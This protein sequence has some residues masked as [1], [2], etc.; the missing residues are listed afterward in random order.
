MLAEDLA[1][2]RRTDDE[3]GRSRGLRPRL[4]ELL[5]SPLRLLR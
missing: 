1:R 5:A 4:L 3:R 2:S